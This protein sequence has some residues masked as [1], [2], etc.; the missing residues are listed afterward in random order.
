MADVV[1]PA[2]ARPPFLNKPLYNFI[3]DHPVAFKAIGAVGLFFASLAFKTGKPLLFRVTAAAVGAVICS[4]LECLP[5]IKNY[6]ES[7]AFHIASSAL[8]EARA[9]GATADQLILLRT[10]IQNEVARA[11]SYQGFLDRT[12]REIEDLLAA[13]VDPVRVP[14]LD[15]LREGMT[16][17]ELQQALAAHIE[18]K[19]LPDGGILSVQVPA[20][21]EVA[22]AALVEALARTNPLESVSFH[23][24]NTLIPTNEALAA[25]QADAATLLDPAIFHWSRTDGVERDIPQAARNAARIH[26]FQLASQNNAGEAPGIFT[27]PPGRAMRDSVGDNTQGPL[28]QRTNPALFE[29]VNAF[30]ANCGFNMLANVLSRRNITAVRHGYLVPQ[31][32]AQMDSI[33]G[34]FRAN[35]RNVE[36]PCVL[37][38]LPTGGRAYLMM[39]AAPAIGYAPEAGQ[40]GNDPN[41]NCRLQYY[42]ALGNFCGQFS[43]ALELARENPGTQVVYNACAVGLGVFGNQPEHVAPAFRHAAL[44]FQEAVRAEGLNVVVQ[45]EVFRGE[46]LAKNMADRLNLAQRP[47]VE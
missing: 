33:V 38:R 5:S 25:L 20:Y 37:S 46:G 32:A 9:P 14:N 28:A 22:K 27:P 40:Q 11:G 42:S 8:D 44:A 26:L 13:A 2:A 6:T 21:H 16:L 1:V 12:L 10:K 31:T 35:W 24:A 43:R 30:L 39:S 18:P 19:T 29:K 36:Q 41:S 23:R 45:F 15:F 4:A 3:I 7:R 47:R 34:E 17:P